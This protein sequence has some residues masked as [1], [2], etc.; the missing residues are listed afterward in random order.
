[1][2]FSTT[3][4]ELLGAGL[5]KRQHQVDS[6]GYIAACAPV[7]RNHG[8]GVPQADAASAERI[9]INRCGDQ[10]SILFDTALLREQA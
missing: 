3:D 10:A 2:A 7:F 4:L 8:S 5:D 1:L 6:A 9:G